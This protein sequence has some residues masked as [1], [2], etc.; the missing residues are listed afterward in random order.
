MKSVSAC[1]GKRSGSKDADAHA[2]YF[3]TAKVR[4]PDL[5]LLCV[6]DLVHEGRKEFLSKRVL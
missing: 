2:P 5:L 1:I 6:G 3:S 4:G